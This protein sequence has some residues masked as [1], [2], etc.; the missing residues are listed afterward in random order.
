[1]NYY[2][3]LGID[4]NADQNQIKKAYRDLVKKHHPDRGG[5]PEHFKKIN[6]AYEIL[7]DPHKR[8]EYNNP[9]SQTDYQFKADNFED[10][11]SHFFRQSS[12]NIR[13]KDVKIAVTLTLEEVL[14]GKEAVVN[15]TLSNGTTESANIKIRPGVEHGEAIKFKN[16]GDNLYSNMPRGDLLVFVKVL[17]HKEFIREGRNLKKQIELSI[18]DLLLG[19]QVNIK[20]LGGK[21]ITVNVPAG[22]NPSTILSVSGY[23][24]PDPRI[25]RTGN[26][27]IIIKAITPKINDKEILKRIKQINDEISSGT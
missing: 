8:E 6:E 4:K 21:N 2:E 9:Y 10:I 18:F 23:G 16:L 25:N 24:L 22:T 15:Y 12:R 27:Y 17:Q 13:N 20:T 26:L 3:I 1:M 11:F 5:D 14:A 19:K 7:K